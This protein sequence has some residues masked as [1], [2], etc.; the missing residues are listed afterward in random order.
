MCSR[1]LR[2]D[3]IGVWKS[4]NGCPWKVS[5]AASLMPP[6]TTTAV[7]S[8]LVEALQQ[9]GGPEF[10][11]NNASSTTAAAS[12]QSTPFQPRRR[13]TSFGVNPTP[14]RTPSMTLHHRRRAGSSVGQKP[15][16]DVRL[17]PRLEEENANLPPQVRRPVTPV[18]SATTKKEKKT[19]AVKLRIPVSSFS[20]KSNDK[21][22]CST[23]T[24]NQ[25]AF[26]RM[27]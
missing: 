13:K 27:S 21:M 12:S 1:M 16:T 10:Q 20:H 23:K 8:K 11:N 9:R 3:R 6:P 17:L 19:K 26:N 24:P 15:A 4:Q 14:T 25:C 2:K 22:H 5:F 18:A 7:S